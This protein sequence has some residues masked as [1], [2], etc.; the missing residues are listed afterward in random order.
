MNQFEIFRRNSEGN[1]KGIQTGYDPLDEAL[2]D[3]LYTEVTVQPSE[4]KLYFKRD[5]MMY[6]CIKTSL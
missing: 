5:S 3:Y 4:G 6:K 1:W 2:E